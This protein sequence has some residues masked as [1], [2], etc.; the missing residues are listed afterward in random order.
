VAKAREGIE[1]PLNVN[2][3]FHVPGNLLSPE[4]VGVR[5]G[6]FSKSRRLLMVQVALSS[7]V[8]SDVLGH[9]RAAVLAAI[10]EAERW[11]Y[12]RKIEG[13]FSTLREVA[14]AV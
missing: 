14:S 7:E 6:S 10:D 13:D 4:F 11:A 3:V 8:P 1:A 9:L 12:Q 5:T 2:V